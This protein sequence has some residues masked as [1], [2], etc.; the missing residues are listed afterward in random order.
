MRNGKDRIKY[1]YY[2]ILIFDSL[3]THPESNKHLKQDEVIPL[4]ILDLPF[5]DIIIFN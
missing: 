1:D 5:I 3:A 4:Y 2:H